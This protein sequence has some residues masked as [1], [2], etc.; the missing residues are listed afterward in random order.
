M[1]YSATL[2][3][4]IRTAAAVA[5]TFLRSVSFRVQLAVGFGAIVI[6]LAATLSIML[7]QMT[8]RTIRTEAGHSLQLVAD[9]AARS[10]ADGLQDRLV[11]VESLA[12]AESL[13]EHGLTGSDVANT[14]N[15]QQ[16]IRSNLAWLGV[17]DTRGRVQAASGGLLVGADVTARPW[18]AA[19]LT[20]PHIGDVHPAK[21]LAAL[22]PNSR[23]GE[24]QRF[25]DF[26][27]PIRQ[28]GQTIGVLAIHGSWDW[29]RSV[30][31]SLQPKGQASRMLEVFIFDHSGSM[32]FAPG[33]SSSAHLRSVQHLPIA[34]PGSQGQ[35]SVIR[36]ADGN[37]Y[38][39][40]IAPMGARSAISNLG[41]QVVARLPAD[42]AFAA[43]RA[44]TRDALW[45]G[46]TA[47]LLASIFAW[48]LAGNVSRPL[49][50][51]A[52]AARAVQEGRSGAAIPRLRTSGEIIEL[53]DALE[54]MTTQLLTARDKLEVCVLARTAQLEAANAEL[55]RIARFDPLTDL[56]NR[57]GFEEQ[58]KCVIAAARRR[59]DA[60]SVLMIDADHF[61]RVN[62]QHGHAVGDQVLKALATLMKHR[63]RETDVVGRIGG[64]EFAVLLPATD[65]ANARRVAD[66]L[67][68]LVAATVIPTAGTVTISC[69]V[70]LLHAAD[71][72]FSALQRA[73]IA[74]YR[75]KSSGRNRASFQDSTVEAAGLG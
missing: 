26:A 69:G 56:Y 7:G 65:L 51:I 34:E 29:T 13:W 44:T 47:G 17:A 55:L 41:W 6:V 72:G 52:R 70:S 5:S 39:T 61:K 4:R 23:N 60:V 28:K 63:L 10:L 15:R 54:Q 62:D 68:R 67:V 16:A 2:Q 1:N 57:R 42:T 59:G 43:A 31:E 37:S 11:L 48:V 32:I 18:F 12:A 73:D 8:S 30:V 50:T 75:A 19:G 64:E 45:I 22:L 14:L 36:W 71:D 35:P 27:A 40:S 3:T 25:V 20:G 74:L 38:L 46:T 58:M 53:S 21:M 9:N 33:D 66:D 24:P 49:A